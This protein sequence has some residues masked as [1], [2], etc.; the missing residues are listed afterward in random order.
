LREEYF[1][2]LLREKLE[3]IKCLN[4]GRNENFEE[5]Q[6]H[7]INK[8]RTEKDRLEKL[9]KKEVSYYQKQ[10]ETINYEYTTSKEE[11]NNQIHHNEDLS[12]KRNK[13][14]ESKTSLEMSLI[15]LRKEVSN[16]KLQKNV[17]FT[18]TNDKLSKMMNSSK[19]KIIEDEV[20]QIQQKI[21][22]IQSKI[23]MMKD[24]INQSVINDLIK[25][26]YLNA[27]LEKKSRHK[28]EKLRYKSM[29]EGYLKMCELKQKDILNNLLVKLKSSEKFI[30]TYQF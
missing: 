2:S 13:L 28:K 16:I 10:L 22:N 11:L 26:L 1:L 23:D 25:L 8:Y 24:Q 14:L 6:V 17:D 18:K 12:R 3:V 19:V 29:M 27:K 4:E 15:L 7:A 30:N 21:Y 9:I 20:K 5:D